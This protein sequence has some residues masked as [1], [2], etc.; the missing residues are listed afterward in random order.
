M[1]DSE[2]DLGGKIY[3]LD[4]IGLELEGLVAGRGLEKEGHSGNGELIEG[5][6]S[7]R[8]ST[9]RPQSDSSRGR[10]QTKAGDRVKIG[11]E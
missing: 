9:R 3:K 2:D 5:R 11:M 7:T 1:K 10:G 8:E 4:V 6:D